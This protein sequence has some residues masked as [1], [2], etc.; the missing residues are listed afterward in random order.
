MIVSG[1]LNV[2]LIQV[3]ISFLSWSHITGD[4]FMLT[5]LPELL[6]PLTSMAHRNTELLVEYPAH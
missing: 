5:V 1:C 2:F 3:S 6:G 4:L